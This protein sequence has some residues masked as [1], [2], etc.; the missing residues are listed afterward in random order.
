V[1]VDVYFLHPITAC[2]MTCDFVPVHSVCMYT[3]RC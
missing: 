1:I 2:I 3:H